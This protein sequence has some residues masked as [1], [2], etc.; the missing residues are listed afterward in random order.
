MGERKR[1]SIIEEFGR[2]QK[3]MKKRT[4]FLALAAFAIAIASIPILPTPYPHVLVLTAMLFLIPFGKANR[5]YRCP[6]CGARPVDEEGDD[7][8][9][10]PPSKCR[11]CGSAFR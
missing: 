5:R 8:M 7:V 1:E 11:K 9:F 10:P 2:R 6:A 4:L 3:R